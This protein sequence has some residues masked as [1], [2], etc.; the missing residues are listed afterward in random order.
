MSRKAAYA[1]R[2]R[3]GAASFALAWERALG[4]GQARAFDCLME[5]ALNGATT[6]TLR[7]GGAI[8]VGHGADRRLLAVPVQR[9][10]TRGNRR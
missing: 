7:T 1:W 4:E 9:N 2:G 5:R 3:A 10:F 6:I 8:E